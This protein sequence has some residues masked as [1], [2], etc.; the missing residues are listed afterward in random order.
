M[1]SIYPVRYYI[2]LQ[3]ESDGMFYVGYTKNYKNRD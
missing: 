2:Y 1:K 3:S